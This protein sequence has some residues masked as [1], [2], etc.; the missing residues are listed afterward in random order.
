M[1]EDQKQYQVQDD[2]PKTEAT[3]K[4]KAQPKAK[5]DTY[6]NVSGCVLRL[7]G[8]RV[9]VGGEYV[10]TAEDKKD[11]RNMKRLASAVEM[12]LAEKA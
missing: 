11:E 7:F 4:T 9:P 1:S 2:Q 12:G 8:V 6:R 5:G 3:A 10:V